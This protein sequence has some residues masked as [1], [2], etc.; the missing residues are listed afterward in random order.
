MSEEVEADKY[1]ALSVKQRKAMYKIE[2]IAELKRKKVSHQ[3][4]ITCMTLL[5]FTLSVRKI[6]VS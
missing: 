4:G 1:A 5:L 3:L 2:M 6:A